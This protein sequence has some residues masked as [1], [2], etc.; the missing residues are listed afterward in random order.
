MYL[1]VTQFYLIFLILTLINLIVSQETECGAP[2]IKPIIYG[3]TYQRIIN[4]ENAVDGSWPWIVSLKRI[5]SDGSLS[6]FCGGTLIDLDLVVTAAHCLEGKNINQFLVVVGLYD[7]SINP[8]PA[9]RFYPKEFKMNS[10]FSSSNIQLGY[11]IALI[12]LKSSV[13]LSP[14]VGIICLPRSN[15]TNIV[16]SK[17]LIAIGW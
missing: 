14:K 3:K 7:Q 8:D 15:D 6:H 16:L 13:I 17:Q 10:L 9:S 5:R 2:T 4:G 1:L 12:K 11:D